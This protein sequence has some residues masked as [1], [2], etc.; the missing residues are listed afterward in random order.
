VRSRL[1]WQRHDALRH[2]PNG[3]IS[4]AS[5][6]LSATTLDAS[7]RWQD[8]EA[9]GNSRFIYV[10]SAQAGIQRAMTRRAKDRTSQHLQRITTLAQRLWMPASA[11]K[12]VGQDGEAGRSDEWPYGAESSQTR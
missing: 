6:Y 4:T 12:T 11:G 2:L 10:F 8:G 1:I 7:L 3:A 5:M 9:G